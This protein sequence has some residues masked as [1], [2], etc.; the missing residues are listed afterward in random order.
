MTCIDWA[1]DLAMDGT[2]PVL[3]FKSWDGVEAGRREN[4]EWI[5]ES[6]VSD[7]S[8]AELAAT[9]GPNGVGVFYL[10]YDNVDG[11]PDFGR[12]LWFTERRD[13]SWQRELVILEY[14]WVLR[15]TRATDGTLHVAYWTGDP[16]TLQLRYGVRTPD[17][18]G[19]DQDC[20]GSDG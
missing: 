20:D 7:V 13:D 2:V 1:F 8:V 11:S 4:G 3:I 12:D 6:V 5:L 9:S 15:A 10:R 14:G 18:D 17:G 19:I 16:G